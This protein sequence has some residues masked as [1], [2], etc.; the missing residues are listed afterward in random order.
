MSAAS[1]PIL[2]AQPALH[3]AGLPHDGPLE[4]LCDETLPRVTTFAA[5]Q[6]LWRPSLT[7]SDSGK[8]VV[9]RDE[10]GAL[11]C[12]IAVRDGVTVNP[13]LSALSLP[14]QDGITQQGNGP[15][16]A[17]SATLARM[18]IAASHPLQPGWRCTFHTN[19]RS[20]PPEEWLYELCIPVAL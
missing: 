15:W 12:G 20:T 3:L 10:S 2:A 5:L 18:R 14:A 17:A 4:A 9:V 8:V 1:L 7:A 19:P 13:P 11:F 16:Q 6:G